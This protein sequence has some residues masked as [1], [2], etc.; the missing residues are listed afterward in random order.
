[1]TRHGGYDGRKDYE[2]KNNL[3]IG[4]R[5]WCWWMSRYIWYNGKA[6]N[7]KDYEFVD[8]G[9]CVIILSA[10]EVEKLTIK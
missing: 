8:A 10:E 9:D 6:Y 2:M 4:Q 3:K 5:Y 1:M 7:A